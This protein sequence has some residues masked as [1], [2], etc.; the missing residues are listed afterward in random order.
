V[1]RQP[2]EKEGKVIGFLFLVLIG[3]KI[4]DSTQVLRQREASLERI[5]DEK[6]D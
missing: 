6:K 3:E 5:T 2:I 4:D 1:V